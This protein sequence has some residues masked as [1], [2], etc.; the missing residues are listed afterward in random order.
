MDFD[1]RDMM[2]RMIR[3]CVSDR[4]FD[5]IQIHCLTLHNGVTI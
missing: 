1:Y 4:D 5:H 2:R 3:K